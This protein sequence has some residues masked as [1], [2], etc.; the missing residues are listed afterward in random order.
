MRKT[1]EIQNLNGSGVDGSAF[2]GVLA[3]QATPT[4]QSCFNILD[5]SMN[6]R[7]PNWASGVGYRQNMI[8]KINGILMLATADHTS[9]GAFANDLMYWA[10][11]EDYG[12][13][14]F[15]VSHGLSRYSLVARTS[16]GYVAATTA[17]EQ[18]LCTHVVLYAGSDWFLAV[19]RGVYSFPAHGLVGDIDGNL[20]SGTSLGG[21][22]TTKPGTGIALRAIQVIDANTVAIT[23]Y[24]PGIRI[25]NYVSSTGKVL[26]LDVDMNGGITYNSGLINL[27]PMYKYLECNAMVASP[28]GTYTTQVN[29]SIAFNQDTSNQSGVTRHSSA[30][31]AATTSTTNTYGSLT[32]TGNGFLIGLG[33]GGVAGLTTSTFNLRR[34]DANALNVTV[35]QTV[36]H[37]SSTS[38]VSVMRLDRHVFAY[39]DQS[40]VINR[41]RIAASAALN[42]NFRLYGIT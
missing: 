3:G 34:P 38:N 41:F 10:C 15:S 28:T 21:Y 19:E 4:V 37:Y 7:V 12:V 13:V 16:N 31:A 35:G 29:L 20:W 18:A 40:E 36:T 32:T 14:V 8:V 2:T 22:T 33:N 17:N 9:S 24:E 5:S 39:N 42:G 27:D 6:A 1:I 30:Y 23:A 25:N 26:L 11:A